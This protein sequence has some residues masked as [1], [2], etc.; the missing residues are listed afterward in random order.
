MARL[1]VKPQALCWSDPE[2]GSEVPGRGRQ[3]LRGGAR[4][5]TGPP[6]AF[7]ACQRPPALPSPDTELSRTG[8]QRPAGLTPGEPGVNSDEMEAG[9]ESVRRARVHERRPCRPQRPPTW[10]LLPH[11]AAR[12]GGVLGLSHV[13]RKMAE[14]LTSVSSQTRPHLETG[15]LQVLVAVTPGAG[16][17]GQEDADPAHRHTSGPSRGLQ[18]GGPGTEEETKSGGGLPGHQAAPGTR[19]A[20]SGRSRRGPGPAPQASAQP[21]GMAGRSWPPRCWHV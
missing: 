20:R 15:P 7:S 3:A 8:K 12:A 19:V 11:A 21:R 4:T 18:E 9:E 10:H 5:P 1:Q 13:V 6:A 2:E 16:H 17:L 14:A